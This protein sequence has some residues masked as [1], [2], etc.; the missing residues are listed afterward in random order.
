MKNRVIGILM[1]FALISMFLLNCG[2]PVRQ[3]SEKD[4]EFEW[5]SYR[6]EELI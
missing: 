3:I 4:E 2:Q 5:H 1:L 6:M